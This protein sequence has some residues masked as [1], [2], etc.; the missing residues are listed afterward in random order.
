MRRLVLTTTRNSSTSSKVLSFHK[1]QLPVSLTAMA[2]PA[3]K[4]LF[5]EALGEGGLESYFPLAEQFVTQSEPSF[6]SVS[7]L[8][9]VLNALSFDPKKVWKGSWRWVSEEMLQCASPRVCGH[10]MEKIKTD[11]LSFVQFESLARCHGVKISSHRVVAEPEDHEEEEDPETAIPC[12]ESIDRFRILVEK[13]STDDQ[14]GTFIVVNFSRKVL[15]QTGD[16]HFSPIGGYH[17]EKDLVL[18]MD[19]ARFKYPPYW[20]PL[21]Q[22]WEAMAEPDLVS[23]EPR[24]YFV[25]SGWN[26]RAPSPSSS[27]ESTQHVHC[28]H[29][30]RHTTTY[31][32]NTAC[33]HDHGH[34]HDHSHTHQ[35]G[36]HCTHASHASECQVQNCAHSH[37]CS[38]SAHKQ[39][40]HTTS[41]SSATIIDSINTS[42][43]S[44]SSSIN[45][46]SRLRHS[47]ISTNLLAQQNEA[48]VHE[49]P[50]LNMRSPSLC[51][52][53]IRTW[54]D[55]KKYEPRGSCCPKH[56]KLA[57]QHATAEWFA[58]VQ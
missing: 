30:M 43:V 41:S 46:G 21:T 10:S 51:P 54:Q 1:R 25:I 5:R 2:S 6:C 20:V 33:G 39:T 55:F 42:T 34:G 31:V 26:D 22:L 11:G 35:H 9:M 15:N 13:I 14:A 3:G 53:M 12:P 23:G 16:G 37:H 58:S 24:G 4:Q 17:R 49:E 8:A 48:R 29:V 52:P 44:S 45:Q 27:A 36:V 32:H 47:A 50:S 7:T 19:V 18:I 38:H 56:R 40:Q 28:S 57:D